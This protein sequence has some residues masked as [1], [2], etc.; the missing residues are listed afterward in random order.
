M[1]CNIKMVKPGVVAYWSPGGQERTKCFDREMS[2]SQLADQ[3]AIAGEA[4]R[5]FRD[6]GAAP[7]QVTVTAS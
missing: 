2:P 7:K 5:Y 1:E 4:W 3:D 6:K